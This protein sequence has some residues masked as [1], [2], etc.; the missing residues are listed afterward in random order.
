MS[1]PFLGEVRLLSFGFAPRGWAQCNGQL[2]PINQNQALFSLLGTTYGGQHWQTGIVFVGNR[3]LLFVTLD[4]TDAGE[5]YEYK[6]KFL[7]RELFEWQSQNQTTQRGTVGQKIRDHRDRGIE[8]HLFV[9]K[10]GKAEGRTMPFFYCG[11]LDFV[12]W[13]GEKPITVKWTLE[14]PLSD[15]LLEHLRIP[16]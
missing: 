15:S 13:D 14:Q 10:V 9:R 4:K 6:D 12:E 11:R 16:E 8:V 3:M 7:S 5:R 1:S 2:L